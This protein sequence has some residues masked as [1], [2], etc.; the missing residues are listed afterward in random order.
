[1]NHFGRVVACGMIG[2]YNN[3]NPEPGPNNLMLIVGKKVRINGFIVF[4][5]NDMRQE[6]LSA[7]E[8]WIKSEELVARE[9][10][11]EGIDNAVDAFLSLFSGKNFGKMIVKL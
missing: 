9:T 6:F 1:M 2:T 7:M 3:T 8:A 5:H 4:D 10:I 11:V